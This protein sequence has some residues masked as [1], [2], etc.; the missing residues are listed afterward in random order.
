M[1]A[2]AEGSDGTNGAG[3]RNWQQVV[4]E[5]ACSPDSR[6][7]LAGEQQSSRIVRFT[8]QGPSFATR[9]GL[10]AVLAAFR[11]NP[12]ADVYGASP[13]TTVTSLQ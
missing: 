8:E 3:A 10:R 11:D 12:R 4:L 7:G 13:F 9:G 5:F 1:S 2:P 6:L